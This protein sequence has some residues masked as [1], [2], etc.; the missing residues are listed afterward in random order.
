MAHLHRLIPFLLV[1]LLV[2]VAAFTIRPALDRQLSTSKLHAS[3]LGDLFSGITGVAPSSLNPPVDLLEGTSIDPTRDNVDLERVYK[4][5]LLNLLL[6]NV[7]GLFYLFNNFLHL[8]LGHKRW[9]VGY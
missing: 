8:S 3:P 9:L 6:G 2:P 1:Q 7:L 5:R 4:V